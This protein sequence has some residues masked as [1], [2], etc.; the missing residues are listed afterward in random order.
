MRN[1][2]TPIYYSAHHKVIERLL[3]QSQVLVACS[4]SDPTQLFG[5]LV[6]QNVQ[7]LPVVHYAYV[8]H[9]FRK[10]GIMRLLL[11]EASIGTKGFYTHFTHIAPS[12]CKEF[13][14]NPYLAYGV[15]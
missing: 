9:S 13:I 12:L 2:P 3:Q 14:H 7:D 1:V 5:Y 8:K 10:M 4:V 11:S 6:H 15:E